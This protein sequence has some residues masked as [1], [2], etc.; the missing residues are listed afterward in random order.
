M[1]INWNPNG[2][3]DLRREP[4]VVRDLERRAQA[5]AAAASSS[6][7]G[8]YETSSQQGAKRAP[9][10]PNASSGKGKQG[11]WRTTVITADAKAQ[12]ETA[13]HQTLHKSIDAGR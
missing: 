10:G 4:G 1:K 6:G 11:R 12:A 9:F 8:R 2:L 3:Y 7:N 13:R 5:I